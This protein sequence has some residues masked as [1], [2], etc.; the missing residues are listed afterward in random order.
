MGEDALY[1]FGNPV[2]L[3]NVEDQGE[4]SSDKEAAFIANTIAGFMER[5]L[6]GSDI[7]V[8]SPFRAQAANIRKYIRKSDKIQDADKACVAVDTIDKMQGQER[9]VIIVSLVAGNPEYA[10]HG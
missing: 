9:E 5:G 4:Q 2:I 10:I 3:Q 7:A 6:S 8:L 1:S